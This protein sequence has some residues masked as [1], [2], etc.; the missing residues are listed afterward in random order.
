MAPGQCLSS[1]RVM[2]GVRSSSGTKW[3]VCACVRACVCASVCVRVCACVCRCVCVCVCESTGW[4][5]LQRHG[6]Q[7]EAPVCCKYEVL[8][9]T[10]LCKVSTAPRVGVRGGG[11]LWGVC[12]LC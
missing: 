8:V 3:C 9:V 7:R 1:S 10:L 5:V 4:H 2:W 12:G 11:C 6:S